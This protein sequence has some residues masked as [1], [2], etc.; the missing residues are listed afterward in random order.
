MS[1]AVFSI[2]EDEL[3][4]VQHHAAGVGKAV[5]L[6]VNGECVAFLRGRVATEGE[7]YRDLVLSRWAETSLG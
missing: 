5:F 3:V 1:N 6:R 2:H 4:Q 7:A